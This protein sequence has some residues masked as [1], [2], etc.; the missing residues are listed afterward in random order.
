MVG[1][2]AV[3]AR[4]VHLC[5]KHMKLLIILRS[6]KT[7]GTRQKPQE[8]QIVSTECRGF[9]KRR[10]VVHF[11]CPIQ[12][13]YEYSQIRRRYRDDNEH[14]LIFTGGE[15]LKPCNV[16]STLRT[17]LLNLQ[18]DPLLYDTHSFRIGRATDPMCNGHSFETIK[19]KGRWK[20]DAIYSYLR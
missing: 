15:P 8:V 3:Q 10:A 2:H 1:D 13:T 12:L 7:H 18:L 5:I 4:D 9:S 16:R 14:F 19:E 6:S 17:I 11:F 20:S